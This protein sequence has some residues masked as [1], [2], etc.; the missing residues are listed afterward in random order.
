MVIKMATD[1]YYVIENNIVT[2][3]IVC[4]EEHAV[5]NKLIRCPVET[6]F[7][8]VSLNWTYLDGKFLPPPRNIL[9]EWS[10]VLNHRDMLLLES[11]RYILPDL[12]ETYS[13]D[14]KSAWT[15]YRND[16]RTIK[17]RFIDPKEVVFPTKPE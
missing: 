16:L 9:A 1:K 7:G 15:T 12:W 6:E 3:L 8:T 17:E 4:T 5:K 14:Q 10:Q 13:T 11:D 2:N